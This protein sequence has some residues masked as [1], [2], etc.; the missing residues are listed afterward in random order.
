VNASSASDVEGVLDRLVGQFAS[1]YDFLRE[2]VQNA[3]DAGS[4]LVEVVLETHPGDDDEVVFELVVVDA[5]RGMDEAIIDGELTRL[6]A[7]SKTEDRTMAGGFGIGFVSVFAWKPDI[8]LLQTGRTGE[9]WELV[10]HGDRRFEKQRLDEPVEGTTIRLFRRGRAAERAAIA[11]AIRDSLW[12]WC[13][14]CPLEITFEDT[15]GDAGLELVQDSPLPE[16][17]AVS[18]EHVQGQTHIRIAFAVPARSVLAR[19]GLV[20]A[21]GTTKEVLGELVEPLGDSL[22][23]LRVWADSPQLR[24][25][26]ARDRVVDDEGRAAIAREVVA[27]VRGAREVLLRKLEDVAGADAWVQDDH[28]RFAHLH[29]HLAYERAHLGRRLLER[30]ILRRASG[31]SV[32]LQ[33]LREAARAGRVG[34]IDASSDDGGPGRELLV[35]A[36][37]AGLPVLAAR[38]PDDRQWLE[39]L[40]AEVGLLARPLPELVSRVAPE[41][42]ELVLVSRL[43]EAIGLPVRAVR[44]GTLLDASEPPVLGVTPASASDDGTPLCVHGERLPLAYVRGGTLWLDARQPLL[45][46]ARRSLQEDPRLTISIVTFAVLAHLGVDGE[47]VP[48]PSDV[49]E[50]VDRLGALVAE[51]LP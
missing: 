33:A 42:G 43:L 28:A 35:D 12:R 51:A 30:P 25:S 19:H 3:M 31:R 14:Y 1:P 34:V 39:P 2:L 37:R 50:A 13:R 9:A 38:W 5:G 11:E 40:L 47:D 46:L 36:L 23:H 22:E 18:H 48:S 17:A 49:A 16:D 27:Q 24:T 32:S 41:S 8:V 45:G 6:F 4:D 10:F 44:W 29:A 15:E 26:L 7:S 20:L 21:E